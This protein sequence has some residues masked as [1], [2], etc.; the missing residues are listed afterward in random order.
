MTKI[1]YT[2]IKKVL[3]C[4]ICWRFAKE[5]CPYICTVFSFRNLN[6]T[7]KS[8][9]ILNYSFRDLELFWTYGIYQ[10]MQTWI[11]WPGEGKV[12]QHWI[13]FR[14]NQT[15]AIFFN[16]QLHGKWFS[17]D[18]CN[19][20]PLSFKLNQQSK[21]KTLPFHWIRYLTQVVFYKREIHI[22]SCILYCW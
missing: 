22:F 6:L 13:F 3:W 7:Y 2:Y 18:N 12:V 19:F 14:D 20:K 8:L 15:N 21:Q 10:Q 4:W 5:R 17:A 1:Q 9:Q 11:K 16:W